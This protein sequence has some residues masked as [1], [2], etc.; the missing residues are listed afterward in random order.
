MPK[1]KSASHARIISAAKKEFLEKGFEQAS[2]RSIAAQAGMTS[3][4]LYRHFKDKEDMFASLVDPLLA[5]CKVLFNREKIKDYE[6]LEQGNLDIM[7]NESPALKT[8]LDSIYRN[9]D[10]FKLLLCCSD[11]TKYAGFIH[12]FV[13]MEQKETLAYLEAARKK[14]LPVKDIKPE[15]LHLLL[16]AYSAAVFEVVVHDFSREDAEHYL[17]TLQTFY[18]PGWRAV[19]GI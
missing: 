17:Q 6:Y 16:S 14:G 3:A 11:G 4:A 1:D 10:E 18:S 5:E 19:L 13:L 2:I 9:F 8:L 15:E 7:W 12:H